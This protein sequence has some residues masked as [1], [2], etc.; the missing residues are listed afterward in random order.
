MALTCVEL[1]ELENIFALLLLGS[2][3]GFSAPPTFL[4]LE[5]LPY[6]ERELRIMNRQAENS[7]DML[8]ELMGTLG[9]D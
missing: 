2:F 8:A 6:M 3:A 4:S 9:I 7:G 1:R 5:L